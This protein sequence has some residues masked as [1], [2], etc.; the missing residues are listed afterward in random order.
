MT[1]I[2]K[3]IWLATAAAVLG[4]AGCAHVGTSGETVTSA[5][6]P[7]NV[8]ALECINWQTECVD[9]TLMIEYAA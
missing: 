5:A 7:V 9:P 4:A 1:T 3:W 6:L 2:K 8:A